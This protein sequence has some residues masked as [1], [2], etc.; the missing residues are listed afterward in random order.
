MN[1]KTLLTMISGIL[2][3]LLIGILYSMGIL[4]KQNENIMTDTEII[5]T[6]IDNFLEVAKIPRPSHHEEKISQFLID[7]AKNQG[8]NPVKDDYNNVMFEIPATKGMEKKP[9]GILQ[10]HMDMVVAVEKGK[11][12]N[13]LNDSIIAIRD[14]ISGKLTANGTSLGA[15]DGIGL[16]IIMAVTQNKISHGKLRIIITVN[17]EDGM[18]GAFHISSSWL[19]NAS[20][21]IN[22]DN[23]WSN[24]I[25]VSTA[26]G[27]SL[28]AS[29]KIE[30]K[31]AEGNKAIQVEISNLKGGHSGVEI[32]KG[33]LNG[34]IALAKFLKDLNN[35]GFDYELSSFEGGT[36][37]NA[38][39][40]DAKVELV[41]NSNNLNN[42]KKKME[43]YCDTLNKTYEKVE[44]EIICT[45]TEISKIPKIVSST[46]KNNLINFLTEV[47]DGV[48]TMSKDME[49]LVESSS[50]LGI[51][52]MTPLSES[53]EIIT[54]IRSSNAE[55]ETEII[56]QQK[57]L[58]LTNG[59]TNKDINIEH[60]ADAWQFDPNSKLVDLAKK[61]YKKQNKED[62]EVV[63]VHAGVECGT[64][65]KL[66]KDLDM[67][68][69]GP[70][71]TD[72]HT[73]R[74]TLYLN[75]IPRIWKLLEG[76]LQAYPNI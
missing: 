72:G 16:A 15:D 50:N 59:F 39:P 21:L 2:F 5:D 76:I 31:N 37:S 57:N 38:I 36:A 61:I 41:I 10:G 32:D 58:A 26:A 27:D 34:I 73:I 33:R 7:F 25:L 71:I 56:N 14:D 4:W 6:V 13:P 30:Y 53:L 75:S 43:E 68:S 69:I 11:N 63:A 49:G 8:L 29:K 42:I 17:E 70:D 28:N 22:I 67:I 1:M 12:F 65:K 74:E 45:V 55:K 48:Y 19:E 40:T 3:V 62:V 60:S 52:K 46:E 44:N 51:V 54:L 9:L 18:T 47:I 24:Q 66:N 23:E 20:F 35:Q 64:F